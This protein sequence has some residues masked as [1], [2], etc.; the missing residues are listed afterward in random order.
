MFFLARL[1]LRKVE[2]VRVSGLNAG[3]SL[4]LS[5]SSRQQKF[6]GSCTLYL[7]N[8]KDTKTRKRIQFCV[9][10]SLW[11]KNPLLPCTSL[12][13]KTNTR[14]KLKTVRSPRRSRNWSNIKETS[15]R[16]NPEVVSRPTCKMNDRVAGIEPRH[17]AP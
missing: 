3:R 12:E 15:I 16:I 2:M 14:D 17:D 1:T 8:H 7:L 9:L 4:A 6:G 5:V 13:S 11:F 10:V